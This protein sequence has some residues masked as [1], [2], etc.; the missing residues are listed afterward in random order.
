MPAIQQIYRV[1]SG[2]VQ[3]PDSEPE[4]SIYE[5]INCHLENRQLD[6]A[7]A[8]PPH[9]SLLPNNESALLEAILPI[10]G[11]QLGTVF[12]IDSNEDFDMLGAFPNSLISMTRI[13]HYC[14]NAAVP[15]YLVDGILKIVSK[16]VKSGR[17]DLTNT[18]SYRT[19]MKDLKSL[20]RVPLPQMVS[21]PLE[22]A[23]DKQRNGIFPST[24]TFP[25]FS[26]IEQLQDLLSMSDVFCDIDN[27][28]VNKGN[29]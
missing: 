5:L 10:N 2:I 17:L 3:N 11:F 19:T 20:F 27:L 7:S 26:F 14:K 9:E 28:H 12:S 18:P 29:P 1:P 24:P 23:L 6:F 8:V 22:R 15:L 21:V 4:D 25:V 13:L 16:E